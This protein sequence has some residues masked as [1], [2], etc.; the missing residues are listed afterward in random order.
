MNRPRSSTVS[1]VLQSGVVAWVLVAVA[2]CAG[3]V[4]EEAPSS[5]IS[6]TASPAS[7]T[8]SRQAA[9]LVGG[10]PSSAVQS[11]IV[12]VNDLPIPVQ[13]ETVTAQPTEWEWGIDP[14]NAER[15]FPSDAPPRGFQGQRLD[16]G[17]S[18]AREFW[19]AVPNGDN[20]VPEN[21]F[22][23]TA[24]DDVGVT[25]TEVSLAGPCE[26]SR[27]IRAWAA[28]GNG[29]CL[30]SAPLAYRDSTGRHQGS[31]Q[32]QAVSDPLGRTT[33]TTIRLSPTP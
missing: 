29:G 22:T 14:V 5:A 11:T 28:P 15:W 19:P 23:L 7:A 9:G 26:A 17:A 27:P 12:L 1:R 8:A 20:P 13:V 33:R 21:R 10:V 16:P 32:V 3:T 31:V 4:S 30:S 6:S 18:V 24:F 2:G 25:L